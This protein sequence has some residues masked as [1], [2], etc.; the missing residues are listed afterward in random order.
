MISQKDITAVRRA[1]GSRLAAL[2]QAEG[3]SQQALARLLITSRSSIAN[4]EVGRQV[5]NRDFWER[6][7]ALLYAG[8][9]LLGGYDEVRA[10][11]ARQRREAADAT[12]LTVRGRSRR[13]GSAGQVGLG[14]ASAFDSVRD[15]LRAALIA[16]RPARPAA[17]G[18]RSVRDL[19]AGATSVHTAYQRGDYEAAAGLLPALLDDTQDLA[20][21]TSGQDRQHALRAV[22]AGYLAAS[23]LAGKTGDGALAWLAA[24]RASAAANLAGARALSALATYQAACALLE[25]PGTADQAEALAVA[26]ADD[27]GRPAGDRDAD[28]LSVRGA[29]LL[30]AAIAAGRRGDASDAGGYLDAATATAGQLGGDNNRLC[31]AF[32]PTNVAIHRL[33]IAVAMRQPDYAITIG[34][35]LDLS[36]LPAGLGGRRAQVHVELAAAHAQ[37]RAGD[38]RAVRHLLAAEHITPQAVYVNAGAR[39]V[40]A[41]L[42]SRERRSAAP[43]LRPLARR[44]AVAA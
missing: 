38:A 2:R 5:G 31:T 11:E 6:A 34:K 13:P 21:A 30:L 33:S 8:G 41:V 18:C 14:P 12:A 3:H 29:L 9:T 44:A 23:K 16:Y 28:L 24:D 17:A 22:A 7:D 39:D 42:L 37:H 27:L 32:G 20:D 15:G 43:G 40:L 4:V 26:A 25:L 10:L 1:L 19:T 35:R 36:R